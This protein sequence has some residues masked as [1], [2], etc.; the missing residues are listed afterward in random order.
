M[1]GGAP[2]SHS[3][4]VRRL[5]RGKINWHLSVTSRDAEGYHLLD[6]TMQSVSVAN[7]FSFELS[8]SLS[9]RVDGAEVVGGDALVVRAARALMARSGMPLG[10]RIL[11]KRGIPDRAGMGGASADC[12]AALVGL[13]ELWG[14]GLSFGELTYIGSSLGSDVPFCLAGGFARAEGRGERVERLGDIAPEA[15]LLIIM[16]DGGLS[17][18]DVFRAYDEVGGD[19]Q[20]PSAPVI[21]ALARGDYAALRGLAGNSL[22]RAAI[23]LEPRIKAAIGDLYSRGALYA[24]M[25][26]SGSAAFGVFGDAAS[27]LRAREALLPRYAFCAE[28]K[29]VR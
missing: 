11:V 6:T 21:G 4:P 17:T 1:I 13:N 24:A 12:A 15:D 2:E 19:P 20:G 25:T 23:S 28:A 7:E 29:T 22:E 10:A 16:P 5:A 14:L 9:L 8:D 26:G 3:R 18:R 27:S